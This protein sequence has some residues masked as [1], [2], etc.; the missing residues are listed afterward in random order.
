MLCLQAL[1]VELGMEIINSDCKWCHASQH[2]LCTNKIAL[3]A[4]FNRQNRPKKNALDLYQ[5]GSNPY[6]KYW[7]RFRDSEGIFWPQIFMK[8]R[9]Q[10][11]YNSNLQSSP[12]PP[13]LI[14]SFSLPSVAHR[15]TN[16]LCLF[17]LSF[18]ICWI[19]P[20]CPF[21]DRTSL[22][23]YYSFVLL[24]SILIT[25]MWRAYLMVAWLAQRY[26]LCLPVTRSQVQIPALPSIEHLCDLL[27]CQSWLNFPSLWGR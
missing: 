12:L 15:A 6:L 25:G 23:F 3:P 19:F 4:N 1:K 7:R 16:I 26:D 18:A 24:V 17:G 14:H 11:H 21:S 22:I 9:V 2:T 5:M 13:W 10:R 27:F 8:A 20:Y